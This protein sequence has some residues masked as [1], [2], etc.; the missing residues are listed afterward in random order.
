MKTM[1]RI[2][3]DWLVDYIAEN[4]L[5]YSEFQ[6][7][8]EHNNLTEDEFEEEKASGFIAELTLGTYNG[9]TR[10]FQSR[11]SDKFHVYDAI[12]QYLHDT[13]FADL[14]CE[15]YDDDENI[16]IT[17]EEL[18]YEFLTIYNDIYF[19]KDELYVNLN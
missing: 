19:I 2:D 14:P 5:H 10:T 8:A 13:D 7:Y 12:V 15:S 6:E 1:G 11:R 17:T 9:A 4:I 16:E 18:V 3:F